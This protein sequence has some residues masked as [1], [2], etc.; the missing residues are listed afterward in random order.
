MRMAALVSL[1]VLAACSGVFA[2]QPI[3]VNRSFTA[4]T[5]EGFGALGAM[6]LWSAPAPHFT[7]G[8]ADSAISDLG[9][10]IIRDEIPTDFEPANDNADSNTIAWAGFNLAGSIRNHFAY[11]RALKAR[12]DQLGVPLTVVATVFSPPAWMKTNASIND[13]GALRA[14]CYGEFAE[15]CVAYVRALKDS[16]GID[17]RL[18]ALQN[19]PTFSRPT[20][21]CVYTTAQLTALLKGVAA[22]IRSAGLPTQLTFHDD[23]FGPGTAG[24][25]LVNLMRDSTVRALAQTLSVHVDA[26]AFSS[27]AVTFWRSIATPA[28]GYNQSIWVTYPWG[29]TGGWNGA[30]TLA[31]HIH[32]ALRSGHAR[33]W[34][35]GQLGAPS[36]SGASALLVDG[37]PSAHYWVTKSFARFVRPGSISVGVSGPGY[38][39][40]MAA[41]HAADSTLTVVA[42]N[43]GSAPLNVAVVDTSRIAPPRYRVYRTSQSQNCVDLGV[44]DERDSIAL[45]AQSITTFI[46]RDSLREPPVSLRNAS[47]SNSWRPATVVVAYDLRG[48]RLASG[49]VSLGVNVTSQAGR[50]SH[51]F[52]VCGSR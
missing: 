12:A 18:L 27:T 19:E 36:T 25:M 39:Q 22:R 44:L 2:A 20:P 45:P 31:Q 32:T 8:S 28:E 26:S 1:T 17:V 14:D 34:V 15:Y 3:A 29:A 37:A 11:L 43:T 50:V 30:W 49:H 21:S 40:C 9:L 5:I 35:H 4:Q 48:R 33:A 47:R 52:S 7:A 13:G 46:G 42:L 38:A 6:D 10:S 24:T 41:Y 51:A 23:F 16:T